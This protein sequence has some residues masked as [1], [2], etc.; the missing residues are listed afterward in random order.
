MKIVKNYRLNDV[1]RN[2]KNK[3][4]RVF[5][6][7]LY[8][9]HNGNAEISF[10]DHKPF[11]RNGNIEYYETFDVDKSYLR[12]GKNQLSVKCAQVNNSP[13]LDIG[14]FCF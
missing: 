9:C 6:E 3:K 11:G 10:N 12:N 7:T 14:I 5:L 13:L 2:H 4:W 8:N 1:C